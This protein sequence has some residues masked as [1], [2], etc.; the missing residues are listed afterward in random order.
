[1][2]NNKPRY[3]HELSLSEMF[4][5]HDHTYQYADDHSKWKNGNAENKIINDKIEEL[6]GWNQKMVAE[7]NKYCPK[8]MQLSEEWFENYLLKH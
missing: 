4:K 5:S 3:F 8:Q 7:W 2:N 1:M 6:G